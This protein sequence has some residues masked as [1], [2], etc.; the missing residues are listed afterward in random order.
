[1]V[2]TRQPR[3][4]AFWLRP[5]PNKPWS[6]GAHHFDFTREGR[7]ICKPLAR[8]EYIIF[9]ICFYLYRIIDTI[10]ENELQSAFIRS[11]SRGFK[12]DINRTWKNVDSVESRKFVVCLFCVSS[13]LCA[14]MAWIKTSFLYSSTSHFIN[15][16][17]AFFIYNAVQG[18]IQ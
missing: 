17:Y 10:F 11:F 3:T 1:M 14:H 7:S 15:R 12:S 9:D 5:L 8:C 16:F 18:K 2:F 6:R 13:A 4:Q